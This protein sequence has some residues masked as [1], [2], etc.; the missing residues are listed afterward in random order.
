[1]KVT[2]T[3]RS[4]QVH[5]SVREYAEQKARKLERYSDSLQ[6][7]E[8]IL[9]SHGDSKVAEMIATPRRG[10]QMIGQA[11]HE[12]QFAALDLVVDK[13]ATQLRRASDKRKKRKRTGRVPPPPAPSDLVEDE[14]LDTYEDAVQEFSENL[15]T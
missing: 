12:D 6:K 14:K 1:M 2:I 8:I 10:Q 13:M 4:M 15:D 3:G 9:S 5:D 7:I 11:E